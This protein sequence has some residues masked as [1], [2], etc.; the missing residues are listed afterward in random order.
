MKRRLEMTLL[1]VAGGLAGLAARRIVDVAWNRLVPSGKVTRPGP[2]RSW[3]LFGLHHA[4][5]EPATEALA[6]I[7]YEKVTGRPIPE[8]TRHILGMAVHRAF[9]ISMGALYAATRDARHP[10]SARSGVLF[11]AAVWAG[12]AELALPVLGL[13]E[14]PTAFSARLHLR[15]LMDHLVYGAAVGATTQRLAAAAMD[16]RGALRRRS[17][18]LRRRGN[19][20]LGVR[21]RLF[22]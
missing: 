18:S 21:Q 6:R 22:A 3:A 4:P 7:V 19:K 1:G 17:R 8:R 2:H 15:M 10:P 12:A 16:D 20:A 11:G 14:P 13:S 5:H 9:G